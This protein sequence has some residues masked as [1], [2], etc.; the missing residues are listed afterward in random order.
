MKKSILLKAMLLTV[1]LLFTMMSV[2][3]KA[4]EGLPKALA[5]G[6]SSLGSSAYVQT[7]GLANLLHK[8]L[9]IDVTV[10][11][12]GGPSANVNAL[13][14]GKIALM[15]GSSLEPSHAFLGVESF[16][17]KRVPL[18][19]MAQGYATFRYLIVA[20]DIRSPKD[21]KGK[22]FI[23]EKPGTVD[24]KWVSDALLEA[25]GL[26]AKDI[27]IVPTGSTNESSR[28]TFVLGE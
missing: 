5:I 20:P 1:G 4:S 24:Y 17:G 18:R 16:A 8:Y 7:V 11:A 23:G 12:I 27:K 13:N 22:V 9:A 19:L 25:Y 3:C 15:T 28:C 26:T 10:E 14:S 6:T 21:L 2:V